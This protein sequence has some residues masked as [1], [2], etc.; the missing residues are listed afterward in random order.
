MTDVQK[1]LS[2]SLS[3]KAKFSG[4]KV[5]QGSHGEAK[6]ANARPRVEWIGK[7]GREWLGVV[8]S[9]Q[10]RMSEP[11]KARQ[12]GLGLRVEVGLGFASSGSV[13]LSRIGGAYL[14]KACLGRFRR[15]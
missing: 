10:L 9:V 14:V 4:F 1:S 5:W 11:R 13:W 7:A 6:R 8:R 2:A 12:D 3:S 15:R